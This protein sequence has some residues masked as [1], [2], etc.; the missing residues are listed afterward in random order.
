MRARLAPILAIVVAGLLVLPGHAADKLV[1]TLI[2]NS[3]VAV[4]HKRPDSLRAIVAKDRASAFEAVDVLGGAGDPPSLEL[5]DAIAHAYATA[6][7]DVR[8]LDRVPYFRGLTT[9]QRGQRDRGLAM[10]HAALQAHAEGRIEDTIAGFQEACAL[11]AEVGD[12]R[13][14]AWCGM[15]IVGAKAEAELTAATIPDLEAARAGLTR[16]GDLKSL[17]KLDNNLAAFEQRRGELALA[18][19]ASDRAL[20]SA[21]ALGDRSQEAA[22]LSNRGFFLA[23]SGD[24]DGSVA[25]QSEAAAIATTIGDTETE[26]QA[27]LN[28]GL[29]D[30]DRGELSKAMSELRKAVSA[31]HRAGAGW[32]EAHASAALALILRERGQLAESRAWL[33]RAEAL[34]KGSDAVELRSTLSGVRAMQMVE[35]GKAAEALPIMDAS[36]RECETA[37][38]HTGLAITLESRANVLYALGRYDDAVTDQRAAVAAGVASGDSSIEAWRRSNLGGYLGAVGDFPGALQELETAVAMHQKSGSSLGRCRALAQLGIVRDRSG[39]GEKARQELESALACAVAS[40][41]EADQADDLVYLANHDLRDASSGVPAAIEHLNAA[42]ALNRKAANFAGTAECDLLIA[43]ARLLSG[44]LPAAKEALARVSRFSRAKRGI[45]NEWRY[46]YLRA[47][48]AAADKNLPAAIAFGQRAVTEVERLRNGVRTPRWRAAV[49]DDR[50]EPYRTLVGLSLES[51]DVESAYRVARLGKARDFAEKLVPPAI[52]AKTSPELELPQWS[53]P[54]ASTSR[55]RAL[56][57]NREALLDFF[58]AEDRIVVF[59]VK[60]DGIEAKTLPEALDTLKALAGAARFPGRP[61]QED[62]AVTE[63]WRRA[64]S[65]LGSR[66]YDPLVAQLDGIDA[67]LIAPNGWLHSVPMA[68]L[69]FHGVPLLSTR[70]VAIVPS[71]EALFSRKHPQGTER[72]TLALGDP[73]IEGRGSRLPGAAAEIKDVA[74]RAATP[75]FAGVGADASEAAFRLRAP[76]S[77]YIHLAAHGRVDQLAPLR[78]RIELAAGGGDDG[79][80]TAEEISGF[81]IPATMVVLSGCDTGIDAAVAFGDAPGDEREGLVRAFLKAGAGTIVASLWELSD[82]ASAEIFP[83]LYTSSS[84][85]AGPAPALNNLQRAMRDGI[86]RGSRN[87]TLDHPFYWAGLVAYGAGR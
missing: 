86:L 18:L 44:D 49:L 15:A 13:Q 62:A 17:C 21:R 78:S 41:Q 8:P 64:T 31:A 56:L 33:D 75:V 45:N 83:Q 20:Q 28:L 19:A 59:V 32:T 43:H 30:R 37:G 7:S 24:L 70:T 63:A 50:I 85:A 4:A 79:E 53:E 66:I 11:F 5:A 23:A 47:R 84:K 40:G 3:R 39:D 36:V 77:S 73:A 82:T 52:D 80:L 35:M 29:L 48:V 69:P 2:D 65:K 67:L 26:A 57:R 10:K 9:E 71:A 14:T 87:Q 74:S 72:G 42:A 25:A 34:A 27:Y 6:F 1:D 76:A 54:V 68:A 81:A 58:I 22:I 38:D 60:R 55:L 46:Q 61:V 12:A 16:V 51:G